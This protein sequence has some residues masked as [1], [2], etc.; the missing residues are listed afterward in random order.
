MIRL[1]VSETGVGA[2]VGVWLVLVDVTGKNI[3]VSTNT[4][5]TEETFARVSRVSKCASL[6]QVGWNCDF[7]PSGNFFSS[8]T[9]MPINA[10][11]MARH[12][13]MPYILT[14][15]GRAAGFPVREILTFLSPPSSLFFLNGN[16]MSSGDADS[17]T[18]L[19]G[20]F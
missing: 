19:R 15:H 13:T 20:V 7:D 6:L 12:P 5:D 9:I 1:E 18:A 14:S 4:P 2:G 17:A 10:R 8:H 16:T 3:E 11:V